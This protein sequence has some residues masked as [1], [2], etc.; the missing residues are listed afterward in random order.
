VPIRI[1]E[2]PESSAEVKEAKLEAYQ[3][4]GPHSHVN[5]GLSMASFSA[6]YRPH[7]VK[8]SE[9]EEAKQ[10]QIEPVVCGVFDGQVQAVIIQVEA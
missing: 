1:D 7:P 3:A 8:I 10:N 2:L 9:A 5:F 4:N 6:R